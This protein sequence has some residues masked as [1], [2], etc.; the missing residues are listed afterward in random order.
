MR[1]EQL[2]RLVGKSGRVWIVDESMQVATQR[3]AAAFHGW[4]EG[5]ENECVFVQ[6]GA[7]GDLF[8]D[9]REHLRRAVRIS[10]LP[11]ISSCPFVVEALDVAEPW[12]SYFM[13]ELAE[14]DLDEL[15]KGG[16]T[17]R[18][19]T[20]LRAHIGAALEATHAA[21]YV[22]CD[23]QPS[24]LLRINGVWKLADFGAAVRIGKP[25]D[26][27]PRDRRFVAPGVTFGV[28]ATIEMDSF[29]LAVL[30]DSVGAGK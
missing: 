11:G 3:R 30:L 21:G 25:V 9:D 2:A 6:R 18:D 14:G 22:H 24:N 19:V 20:A 17:A 26:A 16:L 5:R 7:N 27:L 29:A 13:F 15:V 8:D 28:P 4:P 10:R 23:L 12:D 1:P